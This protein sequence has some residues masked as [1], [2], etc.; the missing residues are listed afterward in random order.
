LLCPGPTSDAGPLREALLRQTRRVVRRR[1]WG[2]R[3]AAAAALTACYLAG[4]GTARLTERPVARPEAPL[5]AQRSEKSAEPTPPPASPAPEA[6]EWQALDNPQPQPDVYREAGDR[7]LAE[8]ADYESALRCY[9]GALD[10]GADKDLAV[11]PGDS[12]LL[13][14]LKDARQK[15]KRD[16]KVR[17]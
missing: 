14:A 9:R 15:E 4:I 5:F 13:M 2:R 3:L 1:L 10:S 6:L 7:Y 17:E 8:E 16:E 12:W 11:Q